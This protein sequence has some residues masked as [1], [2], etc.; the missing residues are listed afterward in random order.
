MA[1]L[2]AV[3]RTLASNCCQVVGGASAS[4]P[5]ITQLYSSH[6]RAYFRAYCTQLTRWV[7]LR[8][9]RINDKEYSTCPY[10]NVFRFALKPQICQF[11]HRDFSLKFH[12]TT[13]TDTKYRIS[14]LGAI[15]LLI[16]TYYLYKIR[17]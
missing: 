10:G 15:N 8:P 6:T 7:V 12:K 13:H 3:P 4:L 1:Q 16:Y 2:L 14:T 17:S 9:A 5:R 11:S